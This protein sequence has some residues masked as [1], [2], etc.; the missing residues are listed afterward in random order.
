VRKGGNCAL[1]V[2]RTGIVFMNGI[3]HINELLSIELSRDI[4]RQ[5]TAC[6]FTILASHLSMLATVAT[7]A[8][9]ETASSVTFRLLS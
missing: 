7:T 3:G 4:L 6:G 2:N 1:V 8:M 9:E 5:I